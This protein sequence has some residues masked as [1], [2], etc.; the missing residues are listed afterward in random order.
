V[1]SDI[2]Y[3]GQIAEKYE[4]GR[5][6]SEAALRT[7]T[8]A[9]EPHIPS[10]GAIVDIGAGT[11]RFARQLATLARRRIIAIEPATGMRRSGPSGDR[12]VVWAAGL[13]EALP[14]E[15]ASARL[16]WTAFTTH[17]LDLNRAA[18]EIHRILA[19]GGRAL[20]WHA[21]P[22]V[23]D[24][25]EWFRWFPTARSIDE[26]RMPSASVVRHAF[27]SAGL[28]F[29]ARSEHQMLITSDLASLA[30]RLAHRSIST[31]RLISDQDFEE[32]MARLRIAADNDE[33][34]GPVLATNV[35]LRFDKPA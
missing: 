16:A 10:T 18:A 14:I 30:E 1:G 12:H 27:A 29:V 4:Q 24:D 33:R 3:D 8:A 11:G 2:D 7:W 35:M 5:S 23:F 25:L 13:A 17:Y 32:G 26:Q 28:E 31:L 34:P 15:A 6:L 21:F 22:D 19:P 20:I 9:V